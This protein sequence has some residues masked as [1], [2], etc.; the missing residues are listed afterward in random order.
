MWRALFP[1]LVAA[2]GIRGHL[3]REKL[4]VFLQPVQPA[5]ELQ[6][7]T[8]LL[9]DV[10]FEKGDLLLGGARHGSGADD[11]ARAVHDL[12]LDGGKHVV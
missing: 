10:F 6:D 4:Q 7:D 8:V 11:V 3:G 9:L 5:G 2:G 12:L 1:R